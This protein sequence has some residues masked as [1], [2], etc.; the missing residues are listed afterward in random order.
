MRVDDACKLVDNKSQRAF[1][2]FC[3]TNVLALS[4]LQFAPDFFIFEN[5][6]SMV[7]RI[8]SNEE[9]LSIG[10]LRISL[11]ASVRALS[12]SPIILAKCLSI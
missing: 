3:S 2:L 6:F 12:I 1:S 5:F 8:R 10:Y 4:C 11:T 9:A 7:N